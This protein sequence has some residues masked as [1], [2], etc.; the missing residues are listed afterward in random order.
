MIDSMVDFGVELLLSER[1]IV[2]Q[3]IFITGASGIRDK[4][5]KYS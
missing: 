4:P 5:Y 1:R 3:V 2:K